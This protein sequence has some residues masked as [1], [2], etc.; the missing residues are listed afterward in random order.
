MATSGAVSVSKGQRHELLDIGF[1]CRKARHQPYQGAP[2]GR[3]S[4]IVE[5]GTAVAQ[6]PRQVV[7]KPGEHRIGI[8]RVSQ[9]DAVDAAQAIGEALSQTVLD[10]QNK[11]KVL[12]PDA[13]ILKALLSDLQAF[14]QR[15]NERHGAITGDKAV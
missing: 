7:R 11:V 3:W 1:W 6:P 2:A 10:F 9:C 14:D 4:P 12:Q 8:G 13:D 15:L 5:L